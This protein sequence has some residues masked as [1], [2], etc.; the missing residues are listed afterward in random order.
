[1]TL[2]A[3]ERHELAFK[4]EDLEGTDILR[5]TGKRTPIHP[6]NI[7]SETY[8]DRTFIN[9]YKTGNDL[10]SATRLPDGRKFVLQ[11]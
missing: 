4:L 6:H 7:G 10:Q 3:G 2:K 8:L 1:M 9:Q 5:I 11:R